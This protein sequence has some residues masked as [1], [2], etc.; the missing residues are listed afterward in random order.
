MLDL[1]LEY[2]KKS[3]DE[4]QDLADAVNQQQMKLSMQ[5]IRF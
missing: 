5:E 4:Q 2:L 3:T 1:L